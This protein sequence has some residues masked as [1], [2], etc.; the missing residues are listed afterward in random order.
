MVTSSKQWCSWWCLPNVLVK[1]S[2]VPQRQRL[3][4]FNPCPS[5][6]YLPLAR[7]I[8]RD[9]LCSTT[10][11]CRCYVPTLSPISRFIPLVIHVFTPTCAPMQARLNQVAF[12]HLLC[13]TLILPLMCINHIRSRSHCTSEIQNCTAC[14]WVTLFWPHWSTGCLWSQFKYQGFTLPPVI[15]IINAK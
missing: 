10:P 1:N 9:P 2:G 6:S 7:P 15:S 13:F 3:C 4:Q 14:C 12:S 11:R 8:R 5:S